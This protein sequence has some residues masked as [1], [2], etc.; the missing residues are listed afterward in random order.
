M[1]HELHMFK[2]MIMFT[3]CFTQLAHPL[4]PPPFPFYENAAT[5]GLYPY[6]KITI[7]K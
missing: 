1:P 4:A 3:L 2:F 7:L 6:S 5:L